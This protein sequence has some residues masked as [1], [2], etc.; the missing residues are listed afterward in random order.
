M[1]ILRFHLFFLVLSL[2]FFSN[3]SYFF[4]SEELLVFFAS[5]LFVFLAI[6]FLRMSLSS[7]FF[8]RSY[9]IFIN[10]IFVLLTYKKVVKNFIAN[11]STFYSTLLSPI[12][13]LYFLGYVLF[14]LGFNLGGQHEIKFNI[15]CWLW[16]NAFLFRKEYSRVPLLLH[17]INYA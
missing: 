13:K 11:I 12:V 9:N 2:L 5:V 7:Y 17:S 16:F 10:F 14:L 6:L 8:N 1:L 3:L 4:F 15:H